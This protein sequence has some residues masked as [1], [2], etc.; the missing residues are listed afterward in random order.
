MSE[1]HPRSQANQEA[2]EYQIRIQGRLDPRWSSW[3]NGL[4]VKLESEEP[5]ITS[6]TGTIVDQASLRGILTRIWNLNL[7]LISVNRLEDGSLLPV[8]PPDSKLAGN[9]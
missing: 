3:F 6:L 1:E 2:H 8:H 5:L 4:A 9:C 7:S